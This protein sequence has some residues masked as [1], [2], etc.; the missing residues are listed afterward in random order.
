MNVPVRLRRLRQTASIRA[1]FSETQVALRQLVQPYFIVPG[2]GVKQDYAEAAKWFGKAAEQGHPVAQFNLGNLYDAGQGVPR[3]LN[4]A[5]G[6][7]RKAADQGYQQAEYAIGACY[8]DGEGV[9]QDVVE[10]YKW[11]VLAAAHGNSS[12][13]TLKETFAKKLTPEQ[14]AKAQQMAN[15]VLSRP[16]K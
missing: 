8:A 13:S 11:F 14:K 2:K 9:P 10:A 1:M 16:A 4:L 7:Y 12:A 3:D 15:A 5:A 6:W